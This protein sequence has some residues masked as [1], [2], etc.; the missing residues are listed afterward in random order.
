MRRALEAQ[1]LLHSADL[2]EAQH[3][4]EVRMTAAQELSR[5]PVL[6][7]ASRFARIIEALAVLEV[8]FR[9]CTC[10]PLRTKYQ[11]SCITL[12]HLPP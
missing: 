2:Q 3:R 4:H 9:D 7:G 12:E 10:L 11:Y 5:A 6:I 1:V 8:R